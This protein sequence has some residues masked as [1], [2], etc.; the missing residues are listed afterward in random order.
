MA[1]CRKI[2]SAIAATAVIA[3][4]GALFLACAG[5]YAGGHETPDAKVNSVL[6]VERNRLSF[7]KDMELDSADII[8]R[9][10]LEATDA[11]GNSVR[12]TKEMLEAGDVGYT[13]F[14]VSE[15]GGGKSIKVTYGASENYIFYDVTAF[16]IELYSDSEMTEL[17]KSVTP[18]SALNSDL[19]LSVWIDMTQYNYSTDVEARADYPERAVR[20]DG[21][22]D[23]ENNP[24]TGIFAITSSA[25][26]GERTVKL[27]AHYL[28]DEEFGVLDIGYDAGGARVFGGYHGEPTDRV[29]VPEGVTRMSMEDVFAGE[30]LFSSLALPS[31]VKL[32]AP[33]V[34]AVD[35]L[36]LAEITVDA[37]NPHYSSYGG[38]LYSKDYSALYFM[39]ASA[40]DAEFYEGVTEFATYACAYWRVGSVKLPDNLHTLGQFCFAYSSVTEVDG[41]G[42]VRL[43]GNPFY[44]TNVRTVTDGD[45]ATYLVLSDGDAP[46]RLALVAVIDKE[47]TEYKVLDGTV[48]LAGGVFS[49]C[50]NLAAVTLPEGLTSI[51][52][53]AFSG[54]VSLAEIDIPSTA[55]TF[56]DSVFY[57]CT[58]LAS[59]RGLTDCIYDDGA[60]TYPHTLPAYMFYDCS[61]LK[62]MT[63]PEGFVTVGPRAFYGCTALEE[64]V[65]P[66]SLTEIGALAFRGCAFESIAL[67]RGLRR[68]GAQA[69]SNSGIKSID[70]S[71]CPDLENIPA[72]CFEYSALASVTIPEKFREIP[73][74]C[75]YYCTSLT[76]IHLNSVERIGERAF[77]YC[78]KLTEIE[79]GE[80][81]RYIDER[82]F[83]NCYLLDDVVIPDGVT[84]VRMAAFQRCDGLKRITLGKS[85]SAFGDYSML[86]GGLDFDAATPAL[87]QCFNVEYIDVKPE[88][89]NFSSIDGL[90]YATKIAGIDYGRAGALVSV[91]PKYEG[92]ALALAESTR[93]VLP[94]SFQYQQTVSELT[95]NVGLENIGKGAFYTQSAVNMYNP[96]TGKVAATRLASPIASVTLPATVTHI[97]A[98]IFLGRTSITDFAISDANAK[99]STD[100]NIV[101]ADGAL[102][103]Y[104]GLDKSGAVNVM[105]GTERI[106][107]GVF[108]NNAAIKS[109]VL[110]DSV[111]E[112]E[113]QAFGDCANLASIEIGSGLKTIDPSAF[114]HLKNLQTITVSPDNPYFKAENNVLY[115]KDGKRLILAAAQNGMM[116]L[117]IADTVTEIC[118]YAFS[119]HATLE[120][121]NMP[122]GVRTVGKYAFY[123]CR[124]IEY[125]V[126]SQ[127]LEYIGERAFSFKDAISTAAGET[128]CCDALK[129]VVM[130][131]NLQSI[132]SYAFYGQYGIAG[133]FFD[134]S[135]ARAE[136]LVRSSGTNITYLTEGCPDNDTGARY[137]EV[138]KYLYSAVVPTIDYDGYS[139]FYYDDDGVPQ[140]WKKTARSTV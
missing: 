95:L 97:G 48:S 18:N 3:T 92:A 90:L 127:S 130:Y 70:L 62:R 67:P 27:A 99:Y 82:A 80:S 84:T 20:F 116:E 2:L 71:A 17:W 47:M 68:I 83:S 53:S 85:V 44:R 30:L 100:G 52:A 114:S 54:C 140:V 25:L 46:L 103:M 72:R 35:T 98:S 15:V 93:V 106:S 24:A 124:K 43:L 104:L 119:Y 131:E 10:G 102:V 111:T 41:L 7:V 65:L 137:N 101:Y 121:V 125:V 26:G 135:I 86:S 109:V 37:G 5:D 107:T 60:K 45:C 133:A 61:S 69:F 94:Y 40:T 73:A 115:S 38:A 6:H 91:P 126:C 79:W 28:T 39:P 59:V 88:N 123:E 81:L 55:D 87:W 56:G 138:V 51:G 57:G 34:T 1:K 63:V 16:E 31:T 132:G 108:M 117:D 8:A 36:G 64:L 105:E 122:S 113:R 139:W 118:D 78:T 21:W 96:A 110:P 9:C 134:M 29:K 89:G 50:E 33:F 74:Y 77:S 58:A 75:F 22:Y 4:C 112:I 19:A 42:D 13:D 12:I 66:R 129:Y 128:R 11:D 23:E 76:D 32:D 14:D 49:G 120:S 136:Q